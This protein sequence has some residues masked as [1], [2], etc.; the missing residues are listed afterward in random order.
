MGKSTLKANRTLLWTNTSPTLTF[1]GQS[2]W[3]GL[4]GY[5]EVEVVFICWTTAQEITESIRVPIGLSGRAFSPMA[6]N[7]FRVFATTTSGVTF[8]D[9]RGFS[10]YSSWAEAI[11]NNA[12]IPWKIYGIK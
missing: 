12:C 10:S 9:A 4:S 2:V 1:G 5:S 7:V 8:E 6:V 3:L 11:Q